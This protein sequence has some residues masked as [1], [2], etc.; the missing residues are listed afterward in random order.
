MNNYKD[1]S[2][3][4]NDNLVM[5]RTDPGEEYVMIVA[6]DERWSHHWEAEAF[7]AAL[8]ALC[9]PLSFIH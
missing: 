3:F 1:E 9:P 5:T 6:N 4:F 7:L 2:I 8:A